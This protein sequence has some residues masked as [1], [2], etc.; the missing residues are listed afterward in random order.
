M[1]ISPVLQIFFVIIDLS[2][3]QFQANAEML[4]LWEM[5]ANKDI[6][7]VVGPL[8]CKPDVEYQHKNDD[9]SLENL[10]FWT[11]FQSFA[12]WRGELVVIFW[13]ENKPS[14]QNQDLK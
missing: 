5:N 13:E 11:D 2:H 14:K 10:V 8:N 1:R 7:E 4:K 6:Y 9:W 3:F 12:K